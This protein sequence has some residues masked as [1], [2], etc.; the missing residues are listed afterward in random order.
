MH[1]NRLIQERTLPN[2]AD[3][4]IKTHT[5]N[6]RKDNNNQQQNRQKRNELNTLQ[7]YSFITLQS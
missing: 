3:T 1:T 4:E 7:V 5:P 2:T 6:E